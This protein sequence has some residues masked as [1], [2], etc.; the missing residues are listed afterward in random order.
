MKKRILYYLKYKD[1]NTDTFCK[2]INIST[3]NFKGKALS[4][5]LGGDKIAKTLRI[6]PDINPKWLITGEGEML[7]KKMEEDI[8]N[9]QKENST[10]KEQIENLRFLIDSLKTTM[11]V[12]QS[13][14]YLFLTHNKEHMISLKK[15]QIKDKNK[16]KNEK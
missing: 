5:S 13:Y 2:N 4:S 9:L 3:S 15:K 8:I 6:F 11:E 1:I 12:Q 10:L 16:P 14:N 7:D